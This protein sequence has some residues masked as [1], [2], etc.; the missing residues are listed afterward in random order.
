MRS[1]VFTLF[2]I[3]IAVC[4]FA[5]IAGC[6][7]PKTQSQVLADKQAAKEAEERRNRSWKTFTGLFSSTEEAVEAETVQTKNFDNSNQRGKIAPKTI[8]KPAWFAFPRLG[9]WIAGL[10]CFVLLAAFADYEDY[11]TEGW[12]SAK[13]AGN[14]AGGILATLLIVVNKGY[15]YQFWETYSWKGVATFIA[16]FAISAGLNLWLKWLIKTTRAFDLFRDREMQYIK[17]MEVKDENGVLYGAIPNDKKI[18][19]GRN[20]YFQNKG[21]DLSLPQRTQ[22]KSLLMKWACLGPISL[23]STLLVHGGQLFGS[24]CYSIFG[25]IADMTTRRHESMILR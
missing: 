14:F 5:T 8:K 11:E 23:P 12:G 10:A 9:F 16:V 25:R 4:S 24:A 2:M 20:E 1:T 13:I 3:F 15:I 17:E 6:P 7:A 21:W 22:H 18:I 19:T